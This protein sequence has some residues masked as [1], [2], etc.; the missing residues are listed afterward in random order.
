MKFQ[1]PKVQ[2][3]MHP[4]TQLLTFG[5]VI[6]TILLWVSHW[7]VFGLSQKLREIEEF[8]TKNSEQITAVLPDFKLPTYFTDVLFKLNVSQGVV[9][10]ILGILVFVFA[11]VLFYWMV[12]KVE[13]EE[14]ELGEVRLVSVIVSLVIGFVI[15]SILVAILNQLFV[16]TFP[17]E[18]LQIFWP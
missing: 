14:V 9:Y 4:H 2:L 17:T 5:V 12:R 18:L 7:L 10:A 13:A 16:F 6:P 15:V 8:L 3:S 1:L 11:A